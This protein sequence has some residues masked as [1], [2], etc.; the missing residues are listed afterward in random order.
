MK[1]HFINFTIF[2]NFLILFFTDSVIQNSLANLMVIAT[3]LRTPALIGT[4]INA[5]SVMLFVKDMLVDPMVL[6]ESVVFR[7]LYHF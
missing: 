5:N 4:Q 3:W 6:S 2:K 1:L 7:T